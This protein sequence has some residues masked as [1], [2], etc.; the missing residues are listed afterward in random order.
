M[1]RTVVDQNQLGFELSLLFGGTRIRQGPSQRYDNRIG[2]GPA[3]WHSADS[4]VI[5]DAHD[6]GRQVPST[7]Q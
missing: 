2:M 7:D 3:Q 6:V 1:R 4:G 5:A